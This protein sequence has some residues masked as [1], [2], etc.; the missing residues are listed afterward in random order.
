MSAER[1]LALLIELPCTYTADIDGPLREY[2]FDDFSE[3][4]YIL[5]CIGG[6]S[7]VR[8]RMEISGEKDSEVVEVWGAVREASLVEPSRGYGD[9]PHLTDAQLSEHGGHKLTRDVDAC[10]WC[11]YHEPSNP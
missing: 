1:H 9:R 7:I 10:E 8:V 2:K 5:N 11:Q 6:P 3:S 4:D